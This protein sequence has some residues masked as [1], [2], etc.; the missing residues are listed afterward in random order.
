MNEEILKLGFSRNVKY[1][2]TCLILRMKR[3]MALKYS[4]KEVHVTF[5]GWH[6]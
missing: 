4:N 1:Q 5:N 3:K 2:K 6:H